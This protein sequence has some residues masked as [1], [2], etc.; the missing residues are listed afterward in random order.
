LSLGDFPASGAM[1]AL[2]HSWAMMLPVSAGR[3]PKVTFTVDAAEATTLR[4]EVRVSSKSFN[5]T[6]DHS[7]GVRDIALRAG[8][9]QAVELDFDVESPHE[10]YAFYM[11][12]QNPSVSVALSERRVTG[13]LALRHR[14]NR[15]VQSPPADWGIEGFECWLP[16][17]RPDGQNLACKIEPVLTAYPV[18]NLTNGV[19]RPVN[20]P[21]AWA[22]DFADS[23]PT[24]VLQWSSAQSIRRIDLVFDTDADHPL[25]SVLFHHPERDMPFCV[26]RYRIL[27]GAGREL[28]TAEHNHQTRRVHEF[29][30]PITTNCVRIEFVHPSANVPAALFAVRV[31]E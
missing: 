7:L 10:G 19:D 20:R 3:L 18:E 6:P 13:V 16:L 25:E 2:D 17:R 29:A 5:H 30:E 21:N 14:S 24:I 23:M 26:P 15:D 27:D 1:R 31:Y 9:G 12:H 4:V 8:A 22:A 28:A 11:L